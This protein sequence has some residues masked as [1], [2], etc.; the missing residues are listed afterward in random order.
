MRPYG[1]A[2]YASFRRPKAPRLYATNIP[3]PGLGFGPLLMAAGFVAVIFL[4]VV[5][6]LVL[7][8][9]DA[10]PTSPPAYPILT[11]KPS[12]PPLTTPCFPFQSSC[13]S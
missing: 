4:V 13:P 7:H 8:Q 9:H 5:V 2:P 3:L 6:G 12:P 10:P 11:A 1:T